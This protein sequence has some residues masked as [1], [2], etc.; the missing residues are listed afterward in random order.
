MI[1]GGNPVTGGTVCGSTK[2]FYGENGFGTGPGQVYVVDVNG[3]PGRIDIDRMSY[4]CGTA[5]G[6]ITDA[7]RGLNPAE[8]MQW[9]ANGYAECAVELECMF[10]TS[11]AI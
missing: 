5:G 3:I 7:C 11:T 1:A 4:Y 8:G 9:N 2:N 6:S 10:H